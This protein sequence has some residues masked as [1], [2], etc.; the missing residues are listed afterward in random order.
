MRLH[1]TW[2]MA[3]SESFATTPTNPSF[4]SLPAFSRSLAFAAPRALSQSIAF[5]ISP[6]EASRAFLQSAIGAEVLDRRSLIP[7]KV[8]PA[9][10]RNCIGICLRDTACAKRSMFFFAMLQRLTNLYGDTDLASCCTIVHGRYLSICLSG[11]TNKGSNGSQ[12]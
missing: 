10:V 3:A 4:V 12:N 11:D 7:S 8:E 6:P 1:G 2:M 5:A 9:N